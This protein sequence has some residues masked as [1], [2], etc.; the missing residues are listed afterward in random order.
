MLSNIQIY[1]QC[2]LFGLKPQ[3]L[4]TCDIFHGALA[5]IS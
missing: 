1:E 2:L 3:K 4:L 5:A